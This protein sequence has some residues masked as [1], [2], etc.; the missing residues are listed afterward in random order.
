MK[1]D[2]GGA[3]SQAALSHAQQM[4]WAAHS[5]DPSAP[6]FNTAWR[7][8]L[9]CEIDPARFRS[10]FDRTISQ[11]DVLRMVVADGPDGQ[12]VN[13]DTG[14]AAGVHEDITDL[15]LEAAEAWIARA[16]AQPFELS[17]SNFH[18]ALI[19]ISDTHWIW[20]FN[21]HHIMTDANAGRLIYEATALNYA[22]AEPLDTCRFL[23]HAR[24]QPA[25]VNPDNQAHWD[26]FAQSNVALPRLYGKAVDGTCS[27]AQMD[28]VPLNPSRMAKLEMRLAER[29]FAALSRQ[30]AVFQFFATVLA[31]WMQ[32][33]SGQA[34]VPL[35]VVGH[36]R[37]NLVARQTPGCFIELFPMVIDTA[38]DTSFR[39]LHAITRAQM[40]DTLRHATPGSSSARALTRFDTVLNV[41]PAQFPDWNGTPVKV[42]WLDN[43]RLD[44]RHAFRL[45]VMELRQDGPI[46]LAMAFNDAVFDAA[47]RDAAKRHFLTL[48]DAFLEDPDSVVSKTPLAGSDDASTVLTQTH[49]DV[50]APIHDVCATLDRLTRADPNAV[51][52]TQGPESWTRADMSQRINAIGARLRAEGVRAGDRVG[53]HLRRSPDLV[54]AMFAILKCGA[55]FVP[56][57]PGQ[58]ANRLSQ[59]A[60]LAEPRVIL[61]EAS[62]MAD[63][64]STAP[65][66]DVASIG[67]EPAESFDTVSTDAPAYV[68]FTSGS[69]GE[70]KGVVIG[71]RALARYATWAHGVFSPRD[72]PVWALHS[73]I[74]FDLTITSIFA[75]LLAGGQIRIYTDEAGG[76]N[77]SVLDVFAENAVDVVKLTPAHLRIALE[78][79]ARPGRIGSLVLGGEALRTDLANRAINA[80]GDKVRIH[81]EYG[82]TEA[83]VGCMIHTFDPATDT[84]ATVP[85]GKPAAETAIYVLDAGLAPVP[86]NVIGDIYIAGAD[87]LADGYLNRPELTDAAFLQ[88]PFAPGKMYKSGDLGAVRRDGTILYHG[89]AD[90][91][92]K[93]GGVRIE[94]AEIEA[95]VMAIQGIDHCAA[96]MF[97][98]LAANSQL[99]TR[100]GVPKALPTTKFVA[101]GLCATCAEFEDYRAK[102]DAYFGDLDELTEILSARNPRKTGKYDCVM[103]LSGGKDSTYALSRLSEITPNILAATLDNGFISDGAKENIRIITE[104]LGIDHRFL[105]TPSMN[106]IFV[107]S[108]K[109]YA[110]VCQGCFK[111]IYTLAF[112]LAQEVGA[113]TVVTGLSR[114]QLFETRLAPE[115]FDGKT[116]S[117]SEIDEMVMQARRSYHAVPDVAA[118]RLNGTLFEADDIFQ[119]IEFVDFYRYCDV[120]VSEVY[121]H[122]EG[123][124]GWS[125]PMDTGRSTNCLINDVGIHYHKSRRGYH[126]YALP[127]SWDVR[128][129]HKKRDEAVA[130]LQDEIDEESVQ[131]ILD[132]IGFDEPVAP[133]VP[134][135]PKLVLYYTTQSGVS[136]QDIRTELLGALSRDLVPEHILIVD[137]I[138]LTANGKTDFNALPAPDLAVP[139]GVSVSTDV[140]DSNLSETEARI[141]G[142]WRSVLAHS[143]L[144]AQDNFYDVGGDS[145]RAIQIS[146]Q[147]AKVGIAIGPQDIFRH[148]TVA[149]LAVAIDQRP[150]QPQTQSATAPRRRAELSSRSKSQLAALFGK[151]SNG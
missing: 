117:R 132:E 5:I 61:S 91:Q 110:N 107:D 34:S 62:M 1:L 118:Q 30:M 77:L 79:G 15:D 147:C 31:A 19:R 36:G 90:A 102:V 33:V 84:D 87:R 63:F 4:I 2:H 51:A 134:H 86:D 92:M 138:P 68:I 8:D 7:F 106:D 26:Q 136:P 57:D 94:A 44:Q 105:S 25:E 72:T 101:G 64:A 20:Y 40:F 83:T 109:R 23:E 145:L 139:L 131:N 66:I 104:R 123:A 149:K 27:T 48:L 100:C 46:S 24:A 129:G 97:D 3:N 56:L 116:A 59:I 99:C 14:V 12:K 140:D 67:Q 135:G 9:H 42:E 124:V 53:L 29:D 96:T 35:G 28:T 45:N 50:N 114:G 137:S 111:T 151:K 21:Q 89:R 93:I 69:T 119:A 88:N 128:L 125:R 60:D 10:A 108:L 73:A 81:N 54:A 16:L 32:R 71:R 74:G 142:V 143:G 37:S 85:I 75:P 98:P 6:V 133:P 122:L 150:A 120:P 82:P 121:R 78:A 80:L 141:I 127:Y 39:E 112:H 126:N 65:K 22:D 18:S 115:L 148:Q 58:P 76:P 52:V 113:P 43:R 17:T 41:I 70:P 49:F 47:Q 11:C 38:P 55:S 13:R 130:E 144:G 103:L 95:R 146:T